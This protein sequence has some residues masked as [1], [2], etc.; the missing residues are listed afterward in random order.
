MPGLQGL[1]AIISSLR[2]PLEIGVL[3]AKARELASSGDE[4][5]RV[6][7]WCMLGCVHDVA[8]KVSVAAAS[9]L[10]C[11]ASCSMACCSGPGGSMHVYIHSQHALHCCTDH[12]SC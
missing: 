10:S 6:L 9:T 2:S 7:G 8:P 5:S 3:L 1:R 4:H 12:A 11:A